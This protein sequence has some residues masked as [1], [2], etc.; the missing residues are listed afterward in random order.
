MNDPTLKFIIT[1]SLVLVLGMNGLYLGVV[2]GVLTILFVT[3]QHQVLQLQPCNTLWLILSFVS[4]LSVI[5]VFIVYYWFIHINFSSSY[6]CLFTMKINDHN[7]YFLSIIMI[8]HFILYSCVRL[9][10]SPFIL[11]GI[12]FYLSYVFF[13]RE[14]SNLKG[15]FYL[16][17]LWENFPLNDLW[18]FTDNNKIRWPLISSTSILYY[19]TKRKMSI[20]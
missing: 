11:L 1:F 20:N 13:G 5:M 14:G 7:F 12:L 19:Q 2:A 4:F 16:Y 9:T 15:I 17:N 6:L 3:F 18:K 8:T 10:A